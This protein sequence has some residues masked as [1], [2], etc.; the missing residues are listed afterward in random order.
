MTVIG[1]DPSLTC[2]AIAGPDVIELVKTPLRGMARLDYISDKVLSRAQ[3]YRS[4]VV[5][6][7]YSYGSPAGSTHAFALGELGGVIRY[8]LHRANLTYV[9]VPPSTLKKYATGKG[10]ASKAEVISAAVKRSGQSFASDDA[11]DAWWLYAIGYELLGDPIVELPALQRAALD[12]LKRLYE[13][14]R[15]PAEAAR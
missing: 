15:E 2:T 3:A 12:E 4:L 13:A 6:E 9:D 14:A 8:R 11:A 10:N 1:V 7:G 5:I